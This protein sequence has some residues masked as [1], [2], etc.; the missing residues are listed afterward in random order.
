[1]N[2][3]WFISYRLVT[4]DFLT[5]EIQTIKYNAVVTNLTP[6]QWVREHGVDCHIQYAEKIPPALASELIHGGAGVLAEYFEHG[7]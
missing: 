6:A 1:M 7:D 4:S 5:Q 2:N 3:R